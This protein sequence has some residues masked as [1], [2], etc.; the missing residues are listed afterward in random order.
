MREISKE[1]IDKMNEDEAG[2]CYLDE[3]DLEHARLVLARAAGEPEP[4]LYDDDS[5]K[6]YDGIEDKLNKVIEIQE[7]M[8]KEMVKI[9][10]CNEVLRKAKEG[11]RLPYDVYMSWVN[12]KRDLWTHW[13]KLKDK[14]TCIT[15]GY[16]EVWVKY[17]QLVRGEDS[18]PRAQEGMDSRM[19][20]TNQAY[21]EGHMEEQEELLVYN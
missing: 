3:Q 11:A 21:F 12:A 17:F 13:W 16:P 4:V 9:Q 20:P 6:L 7:V 14:C 5:P 10:R 15:T 18:F 8:A 19:L 2:Q 1:M